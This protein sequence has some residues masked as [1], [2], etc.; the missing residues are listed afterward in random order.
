VLLG[1]LGPVRRSAVDSRL[2][3]LATVFGI[4]A[5]QRVVFPFANVTSICLSRFTTCSNGGAYYPK[6][7]TSTGC[8][9]AVQMPPTTPKNT[10]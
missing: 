7:S 5:R 9:F 10:V 2:F 3:H 4:L 1:T 8:T 6:I